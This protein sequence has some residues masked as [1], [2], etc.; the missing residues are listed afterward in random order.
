LGY[1]TTASGHQGATALGHRTVAS[2]S[3]GATALGSST[4]ASGSEGATALGSLTIASGSEGATALGY[5]SEATGVFGSTALGRTTL[6]SGNFGATALGSNTFATGNSCLSVGTYN[7]SIVASETIL[8]P[9]SPLFIVGNGD[10]GSGN[11]SNAMV[12]QKN[13]NIGI[14]TNSPQSLIDVQGANQTELI[15]S[16]F[17]DQVNIQLSTI[18]QGNDL[19]EISAKATV[20]GTPTERASII[21]QYGQDS[22]FRIKGDG[23]ATIAGTL[24]ENSDI[25]LKKNIQPLSDVL[26]QLLDIGAYTYNWKDEEK[27]KARQIGLIAQEVQAQF[28]ELVQKDKNGMLSVSYSRLVPLLLQGMKEQEQRISKL[29]KLIT[30]LVD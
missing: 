26:S 25:R 4:L 12:I 9:L 8:S 1:S 2:G 6:A 20:N 14:G 28:P 23:N 15:L 7:D 27:N 13:G 16:D 3:E 21:F 17:E 24:S 30:Q 22:L 10:A 18:D 29:E 19:W 11:E 5:R